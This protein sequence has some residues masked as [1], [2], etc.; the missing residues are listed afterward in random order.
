M[1]YRF[2]RILMWITFHTYFRR[3]R[4]VG[5]EKLVNKPAAILIANHPGSFLDAMVL[6]VFL[7]RPIHFFVRG[8][9]FHHPTANWILRILHM[10]PIFSKEHGTHN[11]S[12]NKDTFNEG[13][14]VLKGNKLLLIFPE[15]F[16]RFSKAL[17]PFKKGA[18]RVALQ[19]AFEDG[20][21]HLTVE[22]IAINYSY[23]GFRSDL[24]IRIG[25]SY[26]LDSYKELYLEQPNHAVTQLN[27]ALQQVFERNVIHLKQ[28][29]R[30]AY[31]EARMRM[32]FADLKYSGVVFFEKSR[33]LCEHISNTS[34]DEWL[35]QTL[36]MAQYKRELAT[37]KLHDADLADDRKPLLLL[38][39]VILLMPVAALGAVVW[40]LPV[41]L[42]KW[43]AD[44]TVT[45]EDFY[46]SVFN[47]ILGVFGF[48]WWLIWTISFLIAGN[49]IMMG[50]IIVSPLLLIL[51]L[52]WK[53]KLVDLLGWIQIQRLHRSAPQRLEALRQQRLSVRS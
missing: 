16:S 32:L 19:T 36:I 27:G 23:H 47:G 10:V 20:H 18:S 52:F 24:F 35:H 26:S 25:E 7:K 14:G 48:L 21:E 40:A 34:E 43:V 37:D 28:G 11:L 31:T 41:F 33:A 15:G 51:G 38:A 49:Y 1:L 9:I 46:T 30:T 17:A 2:A 39:F 53:D 50:Y 6:A 13:R 44:K 8:D 29:E 12:R 4:V 22:T 45:S 42:V 5:A 3:I